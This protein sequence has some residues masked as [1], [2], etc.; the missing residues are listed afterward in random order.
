MGLVWKEF[1][2]IEKIINIQPYFSCVTKYEK[3]GCFTIKYHISIFLKKTRK[4]YLDIYTTLHYNILTTLQCKVVI[5]RKEHLYDTIPNV[6]GLAR[7]LY[8]R[9]N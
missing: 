5:N 7:R 3:C 4:L 2:D 8:S 1:L 6:K 9:N